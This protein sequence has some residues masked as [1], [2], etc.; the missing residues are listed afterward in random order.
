M[1]T[2]RI[3]L[4]QCDLLDLILERAERLLLADK[5]HCNNVGENEQVEVILPDLSDC[6]ITFLIKKTI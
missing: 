6:G 4:H 1:K 3:K 2:I 5:V